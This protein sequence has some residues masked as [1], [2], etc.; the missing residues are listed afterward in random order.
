MS[1]RISLDSV[2]LVREQET[3]KVYLS[4]DFVG[5]CCGVVGMLSNE[6]LGVPEPERVVGSISAPL[7][8]FTGPEE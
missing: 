4:E 5:Y 2:I 6:E 7:T 8:V 1:G 3:D